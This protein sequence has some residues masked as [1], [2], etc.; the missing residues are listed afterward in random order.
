MENVCVV[1]GGTQFYKD[2][3]FFYCKECQTQT[4]DVVEA[5][6][7]SADPNSRIVT[8]VRKK[9]IVRKKKVDHRLTSWECYNHILL[10]LVNEL[11]DIGAKKA[12][13]GVVKYLWFKYL[14]KCEVVPKTADKL[15]KLN[16]LH[17]KKYI[18]VHTT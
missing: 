5:V 9:R 10:G 1:C 3:G 7:E 13:K 6:F 16:A 15:P 17:T 8:G 4:Q 2:A 11:I 14:E 12:L 18:K